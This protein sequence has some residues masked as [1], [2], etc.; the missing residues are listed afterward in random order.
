M[1]KRANGEGTIFKR[2]DGRWVGSVSL[3]RDSN[4]K[5]IRKTV[6]GIT[7]AEVVDKLDDIRRQA[8]LNAKAIVANDSLAAYLQEWLE[9]V[10]A[11]N[12][13][14][15]SYEEYEGAVRL[16]INPHIGGIKLRKLN[17][18][19]LEKWQAT[20]KRE[21]KSENQRLRGIRVLRNALNKALKKKKIPINPM[22]AIDK[23]KV[24]RK[25]VK[26]LEPSICFDIFDLAEKHRIGDIIPLAIMTGLRM[27][28]IFGLDWSAI[29]LSEGTLSV[30]KS[31][32]EIS[33]KTMKAV[34]AKSTINEKPPKTRKSR[35]CVMLEPVALKA[36][37]SRLVK[38]KAEGFDPSEVPIVFPDTR[39]G[40]LR[41]S[42]FNRMVWNPIRDAL[43]IR[44]VTFHDLRHAQASLM[45]RAGVDLKVI[46]ERLGHA[47]FS[48]TANLYAHLMQD[49]QAEAAGK[50]NSL[51]QRP[52][53]LVAT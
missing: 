29:N 8:K 50:L 16:L 11:V 51:M 40:R 38:A 3:G 23:P 47:D 36:L 13:A 37:E 27:R 22:N 18:D 10:V 2:D 31:I 32:E 49:A 17:A 41:A 25:Q 26:P 5:R 28:E 30:R 46:Q 6:Y 39:G 24:D 7:Q 34:G 12:L 1:A 4:G 52:S 15:K 14:S 43:N 45:V 44:H 20:L 19:H 35:R 48:T 21:G 53:D 33:R 42:N 9:N